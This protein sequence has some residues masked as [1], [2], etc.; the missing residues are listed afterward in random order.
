VLC[1]TPAM[2]AM[3]RIRGTFRTGAAAPDVSPPGVTSSIVVTLA[4]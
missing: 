3:S 1:E 2:A 4:A